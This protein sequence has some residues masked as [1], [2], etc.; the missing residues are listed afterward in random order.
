MSDRHGPVPVAARPSAWTSYRGGDC[1]GRY[2]WLVPQFEIMALPQAVFLNFVGLGEAG[3][4]RS[5]G[6]DR[7]RRSWPAQ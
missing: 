4:L 1:R 2:R 5:V 7:V 6:T 3:R